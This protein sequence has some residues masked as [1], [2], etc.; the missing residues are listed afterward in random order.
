MVVAMTI[1]PHDER[2]W[3]NAH[4]TLQPNGG[5]VVVVQKTEP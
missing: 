5:N 3:L 1:E 2:C 4:P